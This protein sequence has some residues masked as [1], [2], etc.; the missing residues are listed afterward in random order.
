MSI[1]D[2]IFPLPL[3]VEALGGSVRLS[4]VFAEAEAEFAL[5]TFLHAAEGSGLS[6][7]KDG[8]VR[9]VFDE[10]VENEVMHRPFRLTGLFSGG[11]IQKCKTGE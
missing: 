10:T 1:R 6:A 4:G 3:K 11:I 8:N 5:K 9:L 7:D 2:T